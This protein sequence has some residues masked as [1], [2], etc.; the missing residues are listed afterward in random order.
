MNAWLVCSLVAL[1]VLAAPAAAM[2]ESRRHPGFFGR[3]RAFVHQGGRGGHHD[4]RHPHQ[5]GRHHRRHAPIVVPGLLVG[6]AIAYAAPPPV[7][8]PPAYA[9]PA[10]FVPTPIDPAA[11]PPASAP[12]P[13]EPAASQPPPEP[14]VVQFESGRYE[15]RGDGVREPYVWVWIPKPPAAPPGEPPPRRRPVKI[16]RWTDDAGVTTLTDDPAKVPRQFRAVE[17]TPRP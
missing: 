4:G 10:V 16:Y 6:A 7:Y 14:R 5:H 15:L 17:I 8:A 12:S 11:S 1:T 9:P 3:S 13:S 2:A